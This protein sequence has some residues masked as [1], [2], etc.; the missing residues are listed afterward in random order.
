MWKKVLESKVIEMIGEYGIVKSKEQ[1]YLPNGTKNGKAKAWYDVCLDGGDG[2]I[3]ASFDKVK[4]AR[5]WAND[6]I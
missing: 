2:D 5:K 6:N 3:V 4:D 1:D